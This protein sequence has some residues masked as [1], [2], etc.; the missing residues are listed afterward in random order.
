MMW[1]GAPGMW[2]K[3][4]PALGNTGANPSIC[5]LNDHRETLTGILVEIDSDTRHI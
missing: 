2:L 3:M 1:K 4:L 5:P